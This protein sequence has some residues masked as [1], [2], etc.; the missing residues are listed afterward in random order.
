M[1]LRVRFALAASLAVALA[2]IAA[3][4]AAYVVTRDNLVSQID[5]TLD[6]RV[7]AYRTIVSG[8][9]RVPPDINP[10]SPAFATSVY[11]QFVYAGGQVQVLPGS[12]QLLPAI[13][14]ARAVA[15]GRRQ[16]FFTTIT[17]DGRPVRVETSRLIPGVAMQAALSL[18]ATE[19]T[20]STLRDALIAISLGGIALATLAGVLIARAALRPIQRLTRAAEH[21]SQTRNL[22][23]RIDARSGDELGRLAVAFNTMLAALEQAGDRQ[24]QLIADA[25]HELRT[26]LT[27]L[28]T[29]VEVLARSDGLDPAARQ[30]L[31]D[32]LV[33]QIEEMT[34]LV[35]DV[36]DLARGEEQAHELEPVRLDL[37]AGAAVDRA[38]GRR[39]AVEFRLE[40][41]QTTVV[42]APQRLDRAV[43][44]LLD[45]AAK[46]SPPGAVVEVTVASGSLSVRDHGP[47]IEPAD[48]PHVFE[49]FYR[50]AGARGLPGSGLGLAIVRQVAE[51]GGGS[52]LAENADDGGARLVLEL[53]AEPVAPISPPATV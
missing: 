22:A 9:Q 53:P 15:A 35:G 13:A 14:G 28:R 44:N 21:V 16:A 52:V 32:D 38:A 40:A 12:R 43:S 47:G 18:S 8:S 4:V 27:S 26:P 29:N 37:L 39:P 7:A 5:S 49:R 42:A 24:R 25:S 30:R 34:V 6:Q 20:L 51:S 48:L 31:L 17:V 46:W 45:N 23:E 33:A 2:V 3:S 41:V 11:V 19:S 1:S 36:V 50:S 10:P